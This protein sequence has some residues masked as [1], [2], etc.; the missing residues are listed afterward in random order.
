VVF[1]RAQAN[2][3]ERSISGMSM[4]SVAAAGGK[5]NGRPVSASG[6]AV[7]PVAR[8]VAPYARRSEDGASDDANVG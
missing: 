2:D 5:N 3:F 6:E 8:A 7:G 1:N 4:R